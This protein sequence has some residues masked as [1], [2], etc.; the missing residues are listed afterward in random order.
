MAKAT[1]KRKR[2]RTAVDLDAAGGASPRL[3]QQRHFSMRPNRTGERN[4]EALRQAFATSVDAYTETLTLRN[5]EGRK[6]AVTEAGAGG[7]RREDEGNIAYQ[8][9]WDKLDDQR[10][11]QKATTDLPAYLTDNDAESMTED[12]RQKLINSWMDSKHKGLDD[13]A[14]RRGYGRDRSYL[15]EGLLQLEAN[16][17]LKYRDMDLERQRVTNNSESFNALRDHYMLNE[18]ATDYQTYMDRTNEFNEGEDKMT[19]FWTGLF[20]LSTETGDMSIL[21]NVPEKFPNGD[22]THLNNPEFQAALEQA[23]SQTASR[24]AQLIKAAEDSYT[25]T[26][27]SQRALELPSSRS[28][29]WNTVSTSSSPQRVTRRY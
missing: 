3:E 16:E 7:T 23:K 28:A 29:H 20:S 5:E 11:L 8:R 4:A 13:A 15:S 6:T 27:Q 2:T 14:E 12:E 19:A 17:M 25:A 10:S 21:A 1:A 24:N 22:P 18:G 9:A 26:F